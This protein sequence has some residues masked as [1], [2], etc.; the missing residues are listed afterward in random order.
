[1]PPRGRPVLRRCRPCCASSARVPPTSDAAGAAADLALQRRRRRAP[2]PTAGR[3]ACDRRCSH[4]SPASGV[5]SGE[6]LGG[7]HRP[8][9]R[10][11]A[12]PVGDRL[13]QHGDVAEADQHPR[14]GRPHRG[15]VEQVDDPR[16]PRAAAGADDRPGG[17]V[18]PG[19]AAGRRPAARRCRPGAGARSSACRPTTT[20]RPQ[21][22]R[23]GDPA[24]Q[25]LGHQRAAGRHHG[26]PVAR[27]Q[28]PRPVQRLQRAPAAARSRGGRRR[29]DVD[30][31]LAA[32]P[33]AGLQS[34][35][36]RRSRS[37][38]G[39][40]SWAAGRRAAGPSPRR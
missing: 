6:R 23:V 36:R 13:V 11:Q 37:C 33:G 40:T 38:P 10:D 35:G 32:E 24:V 30:R 4:A 25:P 12:E 5:G 18:A 8:E 15:P 29:R 20:S 1:M 22:R 39:R 26:H 31:D 34:R 9:Q 16:R 2:G 27:R 19:A 3:T 17:R 21:D 7:R 28:P 14:A